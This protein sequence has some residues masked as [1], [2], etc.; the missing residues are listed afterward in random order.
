MNLNT[1]SKIQEIVFY[2]RIRPHAVSIVNVTT[3]PSAYRSHSTETAPTK[4]PDDI[5]RAAGSQ[6]AVILLA[7]DISTAF[8]TLED[9]FGFTGDV[10]QW[11]KS[12]VSER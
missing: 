1:V 11:L 3:F 8:D 6:D 7:I 9:R 10:L 4:I 12:Y 2:A 5:Y